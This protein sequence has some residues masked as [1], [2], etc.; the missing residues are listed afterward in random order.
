[1]KHS[2]L[3]EGGR[4]VFSWRSGLLFFSALCF[5]TLSGFQCDEDDEIHVPDGADV[6]ATGYNAGIAFGSPS[7][8]PHFEG[9]DNPCERFVGGMYKIKK[10]VIEIFRYDNQGNEVPIYD[11]VVLKDGVNFASGNPNSSKGPGMKY[12]VPEH[13]AYRIRIRVYGYP[14]DELPN[15]G[16]CLACCGG[17]DSAGPFWEEVSEWKNADD[18]MPTAYI[19][20]PKFRYCI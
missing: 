3:N 1:M 10:V 14:C 20:H 9:T 8:N 17:D 7:T 2:L 6:E 15:P 5:L 16:D 13:G 4:R 11:P 19:A 12:Q 18:D